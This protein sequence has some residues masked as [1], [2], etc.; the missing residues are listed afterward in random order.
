MAHFQ[1][2]KEKFVCVDIIT[3]YSDCEVAGFVPGWEKT[4]IGSLFG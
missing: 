4:R 2:V 3:K 1:V